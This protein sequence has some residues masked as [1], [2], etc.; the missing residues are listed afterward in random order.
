[1]ILT[2]R[3]RMLRFGK[4]S[5]RE[6]KGCCEGDVGIERDEGYQIC[7]AASMIHSSGWL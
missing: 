5:E 2:A 4:E 7:E 6:R 3:V 1:M